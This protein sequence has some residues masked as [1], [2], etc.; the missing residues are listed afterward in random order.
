MHH[1]DDA[2]S[3]SVLAISHFCPDKVDHMQPTKQPKATEIQGSA[4]AELTTSFSVAYPQLERIANFGRQFGLVTTESE[5]K[6]EGKL[7]VI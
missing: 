6:N 1:R 5:V 3:F 7:G 2:S 4:R